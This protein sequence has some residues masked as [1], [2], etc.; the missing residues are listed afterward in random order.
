MAK[1]LIIEA[2]YG[3]SHKQLLDTILDDV[4]T[5]KYDLFTLPAKKWHWRARASALYFSQVIPDTHQYELIFASSVLN[6]AELIGMRS[7]LIN[8]KKIVYFHENQLNYPTRELKD[9]DCQYGLNELM[10]W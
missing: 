9:R 7:D 6:L 3:G 8:C 5:T 1:I 10:S 2:F 4:D